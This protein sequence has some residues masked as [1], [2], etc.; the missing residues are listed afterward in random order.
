MIGLMKLVIETEI[1]ARTNYLRYIILKYPLKET[2]GSAPFEM[3][4]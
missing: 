2:P 1:F 3:M 4:S